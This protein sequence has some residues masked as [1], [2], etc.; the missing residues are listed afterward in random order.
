MRTVY[1][2]MQRLPKSA[3]PIFRQAHAGLFAEAIERELD[4]LAKAG[5]EV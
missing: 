1:A 2:R 5:L 3:R 4:L